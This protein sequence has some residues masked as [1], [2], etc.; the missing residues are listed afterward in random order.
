MN[1]RIYVG[2]LSFSLGQDDISRH[3]QSFGAKVIKVDIVMDRDT[4]RSKG[5]G[6]VDVTEDTDVRKVIE[7]ANGSNLAGRSLTVNEARPKAPRS[8]NDT[9]HGRS[10]SERY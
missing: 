4:G 5:F 2:N 1:T 9:G 8:D 6:F 3:M 10:R 7:K